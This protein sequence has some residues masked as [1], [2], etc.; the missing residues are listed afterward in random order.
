MANRIL[1]A[2]RT[3]RLDAMLALP[4]AGFRRHLTELSLEELSA[5]EQRT[6][7][8]MMRNRWALGRH[9]LVRH[10]AH[11]EIGLLERRQ[12]AMRLERDFRNASADSSLHLV[13]Q[14][15]NLG[16]LPAS[17]PQERAA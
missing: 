6:S 4:L 14:E 1:T 9:G 3:K 13:E 5:L 17:D 8:Q 2:K 11:G 15:T 7:V 12:S 10:L 16:T